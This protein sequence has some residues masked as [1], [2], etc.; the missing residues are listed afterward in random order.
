MNCIQPHYLPNK[1]IPS[2]YFSVFAKRPG[3]KQ[4]KWYFPLFIGCVKQKGMQSITLEFQNGL[5]RTFYYFSQSSQTADHGSARPPAKNMPHYTAQPCCLNK[6]LSSSEHL[7][8][9]KKKQAFTA[10]HSNAF[11]KR[12]LPYE[13]CYM[14]LYKAKHMQVL[15]TGGVLGAECRQLRFCCT[16]PDCKNKTCS[17][18]TSKKTICCNSKV[19]NVDSCCNTKVKSV[20]SCCKSK[21]KTTL[22][23]CST[24]L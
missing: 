13:D 24:K 9:K 20:G 5:E 6:T 14:S 1:V 23:C 10:A 16:H 8:L 18:K 2:V 3:E 19:K 17:K 15:D 4:Y 22:P 12:P 11:A 7:E 21:V